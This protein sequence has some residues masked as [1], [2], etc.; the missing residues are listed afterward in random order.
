MAE[1]WDIVPCSLDDTD[2]SEEL[3]DFIIKVMMQ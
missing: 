1:F 3:S 2:A